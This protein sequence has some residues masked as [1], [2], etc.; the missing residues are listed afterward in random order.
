MG[1]LKVYCGH[2]TFNTKIIFLSG[3]SKNVTRAS[4][5]FIVNL[6]FTCP[7]RQVVIKTYAATRYQEK[8]KWAEVYLHTPMHEPSHEG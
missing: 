7:N 2:T 8:Q 4:V 6:Y 5:F 1:K 3:A